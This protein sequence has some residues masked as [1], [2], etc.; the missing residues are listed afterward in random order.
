[1]CLVLLYVL[2]ALDLQGLADC[3]G[4]REEHRDLQRPD[5][6][7]QHGKNDSSRPYDGSTFT[8]PRYQNRFR[9]GETAPFV[10]VK[11]AADDVV[12]HLGL[13]ESTGIR[14]V[15]AGLRLHRFVRLCRLVVRF[16]QEAQGSGFGLFGADCECCKQ[17]P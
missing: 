7:G 6:Y 16:G 1:M 12:E 15:E 5:R 4:G 8:H 9:R 13:G 11:C 2:P 3:S 10:F 14:W 17:D